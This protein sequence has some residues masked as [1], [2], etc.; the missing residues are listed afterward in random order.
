MGIYAKSTRNRK[1]FKRR[2]KKGGR[3]V[4]SGFA[5]KR[6][7]LLLSKQITNTREIKQ[8]FT[9]Q[10]FTFGSHNAAN[11]GIGGTYAT[12]SLAIDGNVGS[13]GIPLGNRSNQRIGNDI[14]IKKVMLKMN[15]IGEGVSADNP[16]PKP[17]ILKLYFGYSKPEVGRSRQSLP[18]TADAFFKFGGAGLTPSGDVGDLN[19]DI[20]T[21]LYTIVKKSRN[22][23]LGNSAYYQSNTNVQD[24]NNNDFSMFKTYSADLTKFYIKNQKFYALDSGSTN[25]GLFMYVTCVPCDGTTS[26]N[27]TTTCTYELCISYTDS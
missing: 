4:R 21:D 15:F 10:T 17:Q 12:K 24:W 20:N 9:S 14:R 11:E 22:M 16:I 7:L 25:R 1:F 3:R 5:T 19:R 26:T 23:K 18:V 8:A 6:D 2:P 27:F 13:I